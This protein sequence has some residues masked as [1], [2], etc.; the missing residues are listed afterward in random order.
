MWDSI[1]YV[2]SGLSLI[3]FI[4]AAILY[5]YRA[6]LRQ[7]AEIIKT[8]P[9]AERLDAIAA[10]AEFFRVDVTPLSRAQKEHIVLTQIQ[11]RARRD[12][13]LSGMALVISILLAV[14][15]IVAIIIPKRIDGFT[16]DQTRIRLNLDRVKTEPSW[17]GITANKQQ[18]LTI[19]NGIDTTGDPELK[20]RTDEL[21]SI[22]SNAPSS[23]TI[24]GFNLGSSYDISIPVDT[25]QK[26]KDLQLYVRRK[27]I[28][29]GLNT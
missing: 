24:P 13:L 18:W 21:L 26:F 28:A 3:A 17:I 16:D 19:L 2:G 14:V 20:Q 1:K 10:T 12:L 25:I 15:A 11:L 22:I 9:E 4:V 23:A 5:A 7:R 29:A 8:A 6:R 27:A